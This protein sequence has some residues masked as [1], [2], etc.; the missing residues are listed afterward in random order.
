MDAFKDFFVELKD[1]ANNPLI[2]SFVIAWLLFNWPIP[3]GLLFYTPRD[4][5][6]DGYHSYYH[7]IKGNYD[8]CKMLVY[9]AIV[10]LFYTF[11]FPYIKAWV[12]LFHA[13]I[14]AKN[15]TDILKV[16]KEGSMPVSKYIKLKDEAKETLDALKKVLGDEQEIIRKNSELAIINS[17]Y[18]KSNS[19]LQNEFLS[20]QSELDYLKTMTQINIII[21]TWT[22][23]Y[24]A[25]NGNRQRSEWYITSSS[26][27]T[28]DGL[29]YS[30]SQF[31]LDPFSLKLSLALFR[32]DG[33]LIVEYFSFQLTKNLSQM[34]DIVIQ[35]GKQAINLSRSI[36]FSDEKFIS[37]SA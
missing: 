3:I 14:S 12:K 5:P 21:G 20:K 2:S 22:Y 17:T 13:D 1:R 11:A 16:T 18:A 33:S 7:L 15:E 24:L 37:V 4:L 28:S 9:P 35:D 36:S 19:D 34:K 10:C 23:E 29:T 25:I 26:I 27:K 6:A 32:E 30:I 8:N 31:I